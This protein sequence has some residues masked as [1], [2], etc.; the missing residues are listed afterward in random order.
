MGAEETG[1]NRDRAFLAKRAGD[2]Q[3]LQF[4]V[5]VEAIAR[6]DLDRGHA[7]GDQRVDAGQGAALQQLGLGRP[8]V[9]AT[10]ETMPPPARAISS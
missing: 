7:L 9:A 1:H 4:G 8:R 5:Q 3:H 2:A 6:L 10:V